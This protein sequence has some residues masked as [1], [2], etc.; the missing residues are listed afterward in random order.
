MNEWRKFEIIIREQMSIKLRQW[1]RVRN[2]KKNEW[3]SKTKPWWSK[4]GNLKYRRI[5]MEIYK[6]NEYEKSMKE[7]KWMKIEKFIKK[8]RAKIKVK[9]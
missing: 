9:K 3:K 2:D 4:E 5:N 6:I 7:L 8:K 1:K